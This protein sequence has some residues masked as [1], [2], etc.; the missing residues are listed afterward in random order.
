MGVNSCL[1]GKREVKYKAEDDQYVLVW[2]PV[3]G[4]ETF[5]KDQLGLLDVVVLGRPLPPRPIAA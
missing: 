1:S 3:W 2:S 5:S 4:Y